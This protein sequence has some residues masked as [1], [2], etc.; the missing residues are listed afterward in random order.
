MEYLVFLQNLRLAA[1]GWVTELI[2]FVSEVSESSIALGVLALIYWTLNKALGTYMLM[3]FSG[4]YMFNTILKNIFRVPRPFLRD[5]RLTPHYRATGF[6]FPSGHTMLGTSLYTSVAVYVRKQK[7]AVG[8]CALLVLMT[9]FGRN[10]LGVHTPQDVIV[11]IA[12]SCAVA[13]WNAFV[14]RWVDKNPEKDWLVCAADALIAAAVLALIPGSGKVVGIFMGV[15][16]GW[17]LERR[18]VKFTPEGSVLQRIVLGALGIGAV[19]VLYKVALPALFSPFGEAKTGLVQFGTFLTV[20]AGW[21]AVMAAVN[22]ALKS[23]K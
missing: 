7:W 11:G 3:N 8:L 6:S 21:P 15:A 12:A 13:A 22:R 23:K 19:L 16:V 17:L 5:E 1:P 10:W 18:F 14:L 4:A 9:A 20:T 2:R